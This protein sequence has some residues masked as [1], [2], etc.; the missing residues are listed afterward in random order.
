MDDPTR[1]PFGQF[2]LDNTV[3][4]NALDRAFVLIGELAGIAENLA[5]DAGRREEL[6]KAI[7]AEVAEQREALAE[8]QKEGGD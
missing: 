4:R 7:A 6:A 3:I 2:V 1:S 5:M 8:P